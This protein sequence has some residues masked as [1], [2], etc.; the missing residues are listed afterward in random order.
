MP[1]K[2]RTVNSCL[3][4][5]DQSC[6]HDYFKGFEECPPG[7]SLG[8]SEGCAGLVP[9][10]GQ[11]VNEQMK[12]YVYEIPVRAGLVERAEDWMYSSAGDYYANRKG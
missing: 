3:R 5:H 11:R 7:A 8:R 10:T 12:K 9:T 2:E 4:Y 6:S 1:T